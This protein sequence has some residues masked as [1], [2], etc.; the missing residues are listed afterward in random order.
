MI[1]TIESI[2]KQFEALSAKIDPT[3]AEML[4]DRDYATQ[5]ADCVAKTYVTLNDSMCEELTV[6]H[7]CAQQR[8][9]L[10]DAIERFETIAQNGNVDADDATFYFGFVARLGEIKE[11]IRTALASL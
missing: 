6:C 1:Q 8:D 7:S 2:Q 3:S 9:F 10:R 5:L 11:N 4:K